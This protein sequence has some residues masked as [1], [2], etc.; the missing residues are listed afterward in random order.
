MKPAFLPRLVTKALERA[1]R[2]MPVA[3][4][5][6]A[7]Q[8][9][10]S[11]LAL[12]GPAAAGRLYL[13]LDDFDVLAQALDAPQALVLRGDRITLDE[14]QRAPELLVAV[15]RAVDESRA[16]GRFLLTGTANLMLMNEVSETLAGRAA[17]LSLSPLTR[18]EQLGLGRAGLWPE[19][20]EAA[21]AD[22][23]ELLEADETGEEPWE[24]L[25]RRG[26]YPTPA[27]QLDDPQDRRIRFKGFAATSLERDVPQLTGVENIPVLRRLMAA[28]CLRLGGLLNQADLGRDVGLAPSTTQRYL[29]V[30]ETS[31]QLVRLPA[32]SVN[33][34]RRLIK[35]PKLYWSD[36]GLAMSLSGESEPRGAHLENLVLADLR[37]WS[38][39]SPDS[40]DILYWRTA[41]GAEVD[42]VIEAG[43]RLLPVEVKAS[44]SVRPHDARYLQAFLSEYSDLA[45]AGLV[46]YC[47]H[48]TYWLTKDVL[49]VPWWRVL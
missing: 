21:P 4:L 42:F 23:R 26:G 40:V 27:R 36:T 48:D 11:T 41:K 33:R 30:L 38:G 10:K 3:V 28:A 6:G 39:A 29:N 46:L 44:R 24:E 45:K 13:S 8:T 2:V 47:G 37:A 18:R 20:L 7:R 1:L 5:T 17:Y 22:W 9:G 49:A 31:F 34:T 14:V 16:S 12:S 15:K 43:R 25:A 19:L 35:S 32:C